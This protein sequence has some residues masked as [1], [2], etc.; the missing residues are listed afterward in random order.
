[1]HHL[2]HKFTSHLKEALLRAYQVAKNEQR[3]TIAPRHLLVSL[4]SQHGSLAAELLHKRGLRE[5]VF[6]DTEQLM[7]IDPAQIE[8]SDE[9]KQIVQKMVSLAFEYQHHYVGTEHLLAALIQKPVQSIA[10]Y[11]IEK[12]TNQ[13]E[14]AKEL[15]QVLTSTS[16]FTDLTDMLDEQGGGAFSEQLIGSNLGKNRQQ[17]ILETFAQDLT[18]P[19]VQ[20]TIDPVI[21]R[22]E[23][24]ERLIHILARRHKNNP[25]LLG[26]P[27]VG[28]T[29]IVEGLAKR[30]VS[31]DVPSIL[32]GKRILMLDLSLMVAGTMYRG[33]FESRLKQVLDEIAEDRSIIIFIDEIHTIVGAGSS[34][35]GTMDAAN[36]L[37]PALARGTLRCIGATTIG[38]YRKTIESDPALQRRFQP[39]QVRE[40]TP[41][42]T[43]T[44]LKGVKKYYE[45]FHNV[46]IPETTL[47]AAVD[48]SVRFIHDRFLPDKAIDLL[49]EAAAEAK[50]KAMPTGD[51]KVMH[52][53][54][55]KI[56]DLEKQKESLVS[57]EQFDEA[58]EL[59][60]K[61]QKLEKK[62][63]KL[64][65]SLQVTTKQ[66]ITPEMVARVVARVTGVPE[67]HI[68]TQKGV[69]LDGVDGKLK[70]RIVGQDHAITHV[71]Q[72]LK[73]AHVGLAKPG[74][75][76]GTFMFMGPSGVGKTALAKALAEEV[77][78][79]KDALVRVDMSE[80]REAF[81]VSK[82]L[83]APAGYVGYK[84]SGMLTEAVRRRPYSVVLFDE[85]EKAHPDI[86]NVLL[87]ILDEGYVTDATGVK[88]DFTNTVIIL[89]S[90]I[91]A[92]RFN[93]EA[94]LGFDN[95]AN[96]AQADLFFDRMTGS[97]VKELEQHFRPEFINR[98]DKTI[99][100]K[101]LS[102]DNLVK[103]V[104]LE[105]RELRSRLKKHNI[106]LRVNT[107]AKK[108]IAH[109]SYAPHKGAREIARRVEDRIERPVIE[110]MLEQ[111]F[112]SKGTL[113]VTAKNNNIAITTS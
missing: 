68:L 74:R 81:T 38:E 72:S 8:L 100:F 95:D 3:V 31:G 111:S 88:I 22:D 46:S 20:E 33:E 6:M 21:G 113:T 85:V 41:K 99:V 69:S 104:E 49:D 28:K 53:I 7:A 2:F 58:W 66:R 101:P 75:P 19:E 90:N 92:E 26:E 54:E 82:L 17:N 29:A 43:V 67:S 27:G 32:Q 51:A 93:A 91:G 34:T 65:K 45:A 94:R 110:K 61:Q 84:E 89:T 60:Q 76:L 35:G 71:T 48:F 4:A 103:I 86:F 13:R 70:K 102:K 59:K 79:S 98:L 25:L 78:L 40:H 9:A 39:I 24:I 87:Q 11:L 36:I 50:V 42:E 37:K 44:V 30:I 18:A 80:F 57:K 52:D 106:A 1:M 10:D 5:E 77:F 108:M 112:G 12:N 55:Q 63:H 96:D 23:E 56:A 62:K 14:L 15:D 73:R 83:G 105:L 64:I 97:I 109:E 16:H 107:A 47:K